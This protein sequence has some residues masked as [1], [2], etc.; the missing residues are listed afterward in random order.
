MSMRILIVDDEQH[1]REAVKLLLDWEAHPG[2]DYKEADNGEQAKQYIHEYS[3]QLVITDMH[4]PITGGVALMEWIAAHHPSIRVI[5][6]S[7]YSD[8]DYVRQTVKLGGMD[9]LL[10][11]FDPLQLNEAVSKALAA[12]KKEEEERQAQTRQSIAMNQFKPVYWDRIFSQLLADGSSYPSVKDQL[13]AEF[14]CPPPGTPC[15]VIIC[16]LEHLPQTLLRRFR[17]DRNLLGY[18]VTN[19][20]NDVIRLQWQAGYAFRYS[21][22]YER[23]VVVLWRELELVPTRVQ[24]LSIALTSTLN[25]PFALGIGQ[26]EPFPAGLGASAERAEAALNGRNLLDPHTFIHDSRTSARGAA[27]TAAEAGAGNGTAGGT[28]AIPHLSDLEEPLKLGMISRSEQQ[29]T[30]ALAGWMNQVREMSRLS[31]AHLQAWQQQW[32]QIRDRLSADMLDGEH[33]PLSGEDLFVRGCDDKGLFSLNKLQE[34]LQQDVIRWCAILAAKQRGERNVIGE[35]VKYIDQHLE[36][37][38]SLQQ[39]A[40][41]FFL[42]REYVSRRFKQETGQNLSE[43]VERLRVD[44]AK[45]LLGNPDLKITDIAAMVGYPDEKYFSKVF[46]KQ[47]G[48]PPKHY[49]KME[50]NR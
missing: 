8:F 49:R 40:S 21:R 10:K 50:M 42:S 26:E 36:E 46:K 2:L 20:C 22:E 23:I 15:C 5:V 34:E 48:F 12:W 38:V 33:F 30:A 17:G 45:L 19:I 3:P 28:G 37:D 41:R 13:E 11:P 29:C 9:Y 27:P 14:G 18:A 6:I 1:A 16:S 39:L 24:S 43:Y 47:T 7:G 35:M 31:P 32:L 4:M 25:Y 44:K